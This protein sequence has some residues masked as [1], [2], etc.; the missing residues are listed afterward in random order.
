M[1]LFCLMNCNP[2]KRIAAILFCFLMFSVAGP[3]IAEAQDLP[4]I[5]WLSTED[6]GPQVGCYGDEIANTPSIDALANKGLVFDYAWSNYP[7]CAPARTTIISGMYASS[8]G[9]G[10]MRSEVQ[11]P[12]GV[13]MFPHYL[14]Q[15]GYYTTNNSKKDY[16]FFQTENDPWDESSKKAHYKNRKEGQPFFAVFNYT[17]THESKLRGEPKQPA[18]IDPSLVKLPPYWP[19]TPEV[20]KNWAQYYDNITV[21]DGWVNN[22]LKELEKSGLADNTIVVF[23]GDHGSGMPRHKRFAGDSGMRVPFVVHVPEKLKQLACKEYSPGTHSKRPVGFIDLAPTML[24]IAGIEPPKHMQGHAFMGSFQ[25]EPPQYLYGCRDR[26]DE[27]PDVSRSIRDD[28]FI[29]VRNYMPHL[30]AGQVLGYQMMTPATSVWKKMFE[31]GSLSDIQ[32]AFWKPHS[33]EELYDLV[34]DPDETNNLVEDPKF[35]KVLDRFRAEHRESMK[36]FGDL[37]LIPE[38]IAFDFGNSKRS[39]RLM[40]DDSVQFPMDEIFELANVA[41]NP[42]PA[43]VETLIAAADHESATI[44]YWAA[45]GMLVDGKAGFEKTKESLGKLVSDSS[46][47]VAIAAAECCAKFGDETIREIAIDKLIELSNMESSNLFA[48]IHALN[49]LN[50]IEGIP[51]ERLKVLKSVPLE[52]KRVKRGNGYVERLLKHL[53]VSP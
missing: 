1:R 15:K 53:K 49:A 13:E 14:R 26:M 37:G 47:V 50:R 41:A 5:L 52:L 46:P 48:A 17:G 21:M 10:N 6:I 29:Y 39:R 31:D 51:Q 9:A 27:R 25:S 44:R 22:H 35:K 42:D 7:V 2:A 45:V 20:R 28:R 3:F 12:R 8:C 30:P 38:P 40:L 11:L 18:V 24:S 36:R 34:N 23:F 4:N 33:P 32:S 16:N 43:D 19:D